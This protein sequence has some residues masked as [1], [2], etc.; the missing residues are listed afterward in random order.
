ME[1][2]VG[3]LGLLLAFFCSGA[4]TAFITSSKIR[5]EIWLRHKVRAAQVAEKYFRNPDIYLS[6]TL[7]GNTIATIVATSYTTVF[8]LQY[9][10][11]SMAWI[12][13]TLCLLVVGEII[14]KVIFN[15]NANRL[16]L[17]L[18]YPVRILYFIL[19]PLVVLTIKI[20]RFIL[21]LF[22]I[23][24]PKELTLFDKKDIEVM[25]REARLAGVVDDEE[26]KIIKRVLHLSEKLVREAMVPR[27]AMMA[28]DSSTR[29][30]K[31][32]S[33]MAKTGYTKLPVFKE[34]IDN[35]IGITSLYDL[36]FQPRSL[37]DIIKP[38]IFTP[39]NKRCDELL[40]EFWET[41]TTLAIVIDEYGGTAGLVTIEDLMEELFGEI[42]EYSTPGLST[43]RAL[44]KSTFKVPAATAI[45]YVNETL[46][47][48]IPEGEYETIAGFI[49][50]QLERF[51]I[52]GEKIIL[53]DCRLVITKAS[54]KRIEEVRII[55][56]I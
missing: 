52:I 27:T 17:K 6:V 10:N 36:F 19:N 29:L 1:L 11:Q 18:I 13:I 39:E 34:T 49:L 31:I 9:V 53:D 14:P 20:G 5:F 55:K 47:L 46:Q 23:D 3:I 56:K 24:K 16:I 48:T 15:I 30:E 32:R 33:L 4:E 26:H 38:V 40:R 28:V 7:V 41:H 2:L 45:E 54:R 25:M 35:I 22:K 37:Q 50:S 21:S 42:E 43:I 44:N 12:I 51:P 8:L